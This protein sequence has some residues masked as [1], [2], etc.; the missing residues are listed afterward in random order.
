MKEKFSKDE[1]KLVNSKK[2]GA[3]EFEELCMK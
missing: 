1:E 2:I 3:N